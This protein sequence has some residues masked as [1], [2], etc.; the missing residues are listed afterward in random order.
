ML[1]VFDSNGKLK[2]IW[3]DGEDI[4]ISIDE[5]IINDQKKEEQQGVNNYN[6]EI[7][8]KGRSK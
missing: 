1:K 4:P 8:T 2:F 5:L 6:E 7:R 3:R